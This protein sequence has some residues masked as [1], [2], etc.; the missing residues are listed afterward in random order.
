MRS[1]FYLCAFFVFLVGAA[2]GSFL[3]VCIYRM[4]LTG[5]SVAKPTF[6]FC[7][8]C[9][10]TLAWYDNLPLLSYLW[11]SGRCRRCGTV[12]SSRYFW[13]ELFTALMFLLLFLH[14]GPS[15]AFLSTVILGSG[16]IVITFTDLDEYI[17]PD[18]ISFGGF[19][20][21]LVLSI[22]AWLAFSVDSPLTAGLA[23]RHPKTALLGA[24]IGAGFLFGI[25]WVGTRVFRKEAMGFGDVKLLGMMGAFI[26]PVNIILTVFLASCIGAFFGL[27][28]I[29]VNALLR[30]RTYAHIP[31]GP[32][33]AVGG[34]L[35]IFIG[36]AILEQLF[37]P[38]TWA[39]LRE[40]WF[41]R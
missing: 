29:G 12:Y 6:S 25:G 18:E 27:A 4:P 2:V 8:T 33:L 37:P 32:Y 19:G 17:I 14:F 16:L 3:N 7:F 39:I 1:A 36:Q 40:N 26:G 9:G 21:G 30:R 20:V 5:R 31:F 41:G 24:L 23:V 11:L 10:S 13:I 22:I 15:L 34:F 28:R 35:S 38:E